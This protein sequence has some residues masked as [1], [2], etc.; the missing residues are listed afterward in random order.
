MAEGDISWGKEYMDKMRS[1]PHYTQG[2]QI[3]EKMVLNHVST[4]QILAFT[5]LTENE[6][7]AM[8]AGDGAFSNQQYTDLFVQIEKHG[9]K[10][11][12]G[13]D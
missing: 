1:L 11:A 9:H 8:L 7:A 12:Q 3:V 13:S 6:F 4:E 10:P 5:G 2:H